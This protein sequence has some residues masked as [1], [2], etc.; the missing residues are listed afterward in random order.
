MPVPFLVRRVFTLGPV[1]RLGGGAFSAHAFGDDPLLAPRQDPVDPVGTAVPAPTPPAD[2][3]ALRPYSG[4]RH[5]PTPGKNARRPHPA[6]TAPARDHAA[7]RANRPRPRPARRTDP[8][9]PTTCAAPPA[10]PSRPVSRPRNAPASPPCRC[11]IP[12]PPASTSATPAT[13]SA[14]SPPPTGPTPS[15][16]SPPTR[17][18]CAQL[19]AWL[20]Q[21]GV[22]T[23]ALEATGACGHVLFLTL[24]EAGFS[25]LTAP[26]QFARQIKG[27]PKT[28]R[29]DCQWIQRLHKHGLLPS[30]FQP[31]DATHTLRDF[32][33][34]RANLMRLSAA[35]TSNACRRPWS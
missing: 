29:R 34:Q 5:G 13:G 14:S 11:S 2:A 33:R 4:D 23:V 19:V 28:D 24:L 26:P 3:L 30:V 21:C 7:P 17:P 22:T 16:S 32:V 31:D 10:S 15:A 1:V 18:D 35:S 9:P 25:T 6:T 8:T 12:T 20:R 27:R